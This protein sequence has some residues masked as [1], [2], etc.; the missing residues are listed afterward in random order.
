MIDKRP[1]Y[2]ILNEL[3]DQHPNQSSFLESIEEGFKDVKSITDA[4]KRALK[5]YPI[6]F[7]SRVPQEDGDWTSKLHLWAENGVREILDLDPIYLAFKNSYGDSVLMSL[8]VAATG[9][10]T[11]HPDYD[12]IKK[13]AEND[14]SYEESTRNKDGDE[15]IITKNAMD[16]TDIS[17]KTPLQYITEIAY[18]IGDYEG[19]EPD[20]QMQNYLPKNQQSIDEQPN[21]VDQPEISSEPLKN[22]L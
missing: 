6:Q 15:E 11:G 10:H 20:F 21:Q 16:E 2:A 8:A 12:L 5:Q 3:K 18:A 1:F 17:G 14:Y 9:T 7:V 4:E 19:E 13:I 22:P